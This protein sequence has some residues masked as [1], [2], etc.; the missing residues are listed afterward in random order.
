LTIE[1]AL[2]LPTSRGAAEIGKK[3]QLGA[4]ELHVF[5]PGVS[6]RRKRTCERCPR[7]L[8]SPKKIGR[9]KK[10]MDQELDELPVSGDEAVQESAGL[11]RSVDAGQRRHWLLPILVLLPLGA[12]LCGLGVL[13]IS[14][15]VQGREEAAVEAEREGAI[16]PPLRVKLQPRGEPIV[17]FDATTQKRI[18]LR[19]WRPITRRADVA[20][21]R[22]R[23]HCPHI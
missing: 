16:K 1:Q 14:G 22:A 10:A 6:L 12:L 23:L 20:R 19:T 3:P 11:N 21:M 8:R 7:S 2:A 5:Q 17:T 15:F 9:V 18:D 13:V 4:A